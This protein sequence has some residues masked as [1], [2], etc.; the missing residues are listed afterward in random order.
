MPANR[1]RQRQHHEGH[2]MRLGPGGGEQ[3]AGFH[4][5]VAHRGFHPKQEVGGEQR[6]LAR[7]GLAHQSCGG[8]FMRPTRKSVTTVKKAMTSATS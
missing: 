7:R 1:E 2:R 8:P 5:A 3:S 6:L 4:I